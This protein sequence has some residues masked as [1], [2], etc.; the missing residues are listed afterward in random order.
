[1][2]FFNLAILG[3][4]SVAL[5]SPSPKKHDGDR[6]DISG[7]GKKHDGDRFDISGPGKKHD[8]D[9]FD[10]SGPGK[11]HGN[12]HFNISRPGKKNDDDKS[13]RNC[14]SKNDVDEIVDVYKILISGF[15][16]ED[17]NKYLS[18]DWVDVSQSINTFIGKQPDAVTFNKTSFISSQSNSQLPEPT[19]EIQGEPIFTCDRIILIWVATFGAGRPA[20]GIT[21]I[22]TVKHNGQWQMQ[23][24]DVEFNS[25]NW[26]YNMGGYYCVAGQVAGESSACSAQNNPRALFA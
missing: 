14:L 16:E 2:R 11:K 7:P 3:L 21:V 4:A 15:N 23:R 20:K 12:G 25:L 9:R 1:M 5:A 24:W 26:A 8:G 19:L 18:E 6:S 13:C 17:A 10:I 22:K